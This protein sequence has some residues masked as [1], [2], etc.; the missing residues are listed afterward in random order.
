MSDW[1]GGSWNKEGSERSGSK[2]EAG[3]SAGRNVKEDRGSKGIRRD[4]RNDKGG[5]I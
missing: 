5:E 3:E 1:K 4:G 2:K